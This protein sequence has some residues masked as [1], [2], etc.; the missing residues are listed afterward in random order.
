MVTS[1]TNV[2]AS[3]HAD[4]VADEVAVGMT[5]ATGE[6][7]V[8]GMITV[9]VIAVVGTNMGVGVVRVPQAERKKIIDK[10]TI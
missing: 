3:T 7:P 8:W 4:E 6:P 10:L 2:A 9:G 1:S 5:A